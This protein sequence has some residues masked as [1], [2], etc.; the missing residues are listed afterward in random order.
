VTLTNWRE[1]PI[2]RKHDCK[3]FDCDE[4]DL[5]DSL[6]KFAR[7]SHES[8]ASKTYV[9]VNDADNVTI[10]GFHTLSPARNALA[11]EWARPE[12]IAANLGGG[13][14]SGLSGQME[15]L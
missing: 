4:A 14:R 1:E 7:Q 9:D 15:L 13:D 11:Q 10:L 8:G 3:G 2:S 6:T 5:N 12:D